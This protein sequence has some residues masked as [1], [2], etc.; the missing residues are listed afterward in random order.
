MSN[1]MTLFGEGGNSLVSSDLFAELQNT[2]DNL[3]G[4]S[5]GGGM[6][7]ISIRGGRFRQI[8]GGEQ[9]QVRSDDLPVVIL[10]AGKVSRTFYAGSYDPENPTPPKCWSSDSQKPDASVPEDQRQASA[11]AQCPQNIKGSGQGQSRACRFGQR[12][13]IA[14]EGDMET[15][16]QLQIPATSIFGEAVGNDMGLQAYSK[17]LSAHKTPPIAVVTEL[18]FDENSETPKLFFRPMRPLNEAEMKAALALRKHPDV[19][20]ALTLTVSQ[21]D[22][23]QK[24]APQ[25]EAPE[26]EAPKATN[27]V[28]A[29]APAEEPEVV[30][31]PVKAKTTK[32]EE[33]AVADGNAE[34]DSIIDDWDDAEG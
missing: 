21:A 30:E 10:D 4:G 6:P 12:L 8:L 18:K 22:G 32:S 25:V 7:R 19:E 1:E 13:A 5:G 17:L 28:L 15:V 23:V 20:K 33:K 16:Y 3:T 27:N 24:S 11:C 9:V 34:L 29:N 31:E 2:L 14:V 26:K